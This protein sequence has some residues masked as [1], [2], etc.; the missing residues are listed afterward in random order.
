MFVWLFQVFA[1]LQLT[2][3]QKETLSLPM[4]LAQLLI[5]CSKSY[6]KRLYMTHLTNPSPFSFLIFFYTENRK[7]C[8]ETYVMFVDLDADVKHLTVGIWICVIATDDFT[9]A[10]ERRFGHVIMVVI[11]RTSNSP[12]CRI[13]APAQH[14]QCQHT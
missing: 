12:Q 9:G 10:R 1:C 14:A 11:G 13:H 8:V 3:N 4:I 5:S 2:P 7:M 6:L